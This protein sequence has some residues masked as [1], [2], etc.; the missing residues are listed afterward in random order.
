MGILQVIERAKVDPKFEAELKLAALRVS[1]EGFESDAFRGLMF[2]FADSPEKMAR[3]VSEEGE[4][5]RP[6]TRT[7][8]T[9]TTTTTTVACTTT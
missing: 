3:L 9:T 2:H 6:R 4:A 8:L 1:S 7:T 5:A